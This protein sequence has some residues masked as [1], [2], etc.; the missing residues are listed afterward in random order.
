MTRISIPAGYTKKDMTLMFR[1]RDKK[2]Q[3]FGPSLVVFIKLIVPSVDLMDKSINEK[4][5]FAK[6]ESSL[7]TNDPQDLSGTEI[8]EV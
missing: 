4:S 6:E 5:S 1:L 2:M 7:I 3:F 8:S